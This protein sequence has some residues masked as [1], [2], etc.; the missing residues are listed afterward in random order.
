MQEFFRDPFGIPM[1][2]VPGCNLFVA[3]LPMTKL[4]FETYLCDVLDKELDSSWYKSV[5]NKNPRI[6]TQSLSP[7]NYWKAFLTGVSIRHATRFARWCGPGYRLPTVGEWQVIFDA[8]STRELDLPE[9]ATES[10]FRRRRFHRLYQALTG[11]AQI[12]VHFG[13][14]NTLA[15]GTW[16]EG[17]VLEWVRSTGQVGPNEACGLPDPRFFA[18]LKEPATPVAVAKSDERADFPFGFRLVFE[19]EQAGEEGSP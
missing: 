2:P 16:M 1:L 13:H 12:R 7:L 17:G 8:L 11:I 19:P 10:L 9:W 4:Q 3:T 18:V 15:A 6:P 14:P 5:L